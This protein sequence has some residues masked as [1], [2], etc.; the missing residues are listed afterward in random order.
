MGTNET[1]VSPYLLRPVR[2]YKDAMRDR[3][4]KI[5]CKSRHH[6]VGSAGSCCSVRR[7]ADD[8]EPST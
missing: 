4:A 3:A 7:G 6:G 8:V 1:I 5:Q 2:S